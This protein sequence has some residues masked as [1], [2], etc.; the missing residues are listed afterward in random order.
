MLILLIFFTKGTE[1]FDALNKIVSNTRLV[2]DIKK[3]SPETQ[4]SALESYHAV[5][6]FWH[7]K[8]LCFSW[9]GSKCRSVH[10]EWVN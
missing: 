2:K 1:A 8:M 4:T 7:P 3:M 6:N 9:M 10:K 5:L